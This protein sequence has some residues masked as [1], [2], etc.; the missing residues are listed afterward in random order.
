MKS[1]GYPATVRNGGYPAKANAYR[2]DSRR[3]RLGAMGY[4][5]R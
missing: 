4:E 3:T 1:L 2:Q 5:A